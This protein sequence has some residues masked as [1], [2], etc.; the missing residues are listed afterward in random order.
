M[1]RLFL[2][3]PAMRP[4]GARL[5]S[6]SSIQNFHSVAGTR[7]SALGNAGVPSAVSRPFT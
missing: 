1:L 5:I 6:P 3:S 7:I 4:A 2:N